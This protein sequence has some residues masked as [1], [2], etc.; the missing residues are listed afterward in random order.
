MAGFMKGGGDAC[1]QG[2][3]H[4]QIWSRGVF[5]DP[6]RLHRELLSRFLETSIQ[7]ESSGINHYDWRENCKPDAVYLWYRS[8]TSLKTKSIE[9]H[10]YPIAS[11]NLR[12]C[13]ESRLKYQAVY[14]IVR[15]DDISP[16]PQTFGTSCT[17]IKGG[18]AKA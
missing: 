10:F 3:D 11:L 16:V 5:R 1:L 8:D 18:E 17:A 15:P 13:V 14:N 9:S 2:E 4:C 7:L 6:I 12:I